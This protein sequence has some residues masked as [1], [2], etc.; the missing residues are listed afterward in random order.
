M[1]AIDACLRSTLV[2]A[3][4]DLVR[5]WYD[6]LK[7]AFGRPVGVICGGEYSIED[8]TVTTIPPTCIWKTLAKN[9]V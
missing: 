1:M 6:R 8:I 9:S 4:I 2:V 3:P 7:T 5:Q